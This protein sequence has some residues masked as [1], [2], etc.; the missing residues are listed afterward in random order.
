MLC[1][2]GAEKAGKCAVWGCI[3]T[4]VKAKIRNRLQRKD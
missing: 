3:L 2:L 4:L 1:I